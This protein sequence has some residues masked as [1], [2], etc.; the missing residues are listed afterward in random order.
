MVFQRCGI[1]PLSSKRSIRQADTDNNDG[2]N[3]DDNNDDDRNDDDRNGDDRNDDNDVDNDR[4]SSRSRSRTDGEFDL[5]RNVSR[6]ADR[7]NRA[8]VFNYSKHGI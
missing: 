7:L 2:D 8:G 6:V 4:E 5:P 3:N 1:T